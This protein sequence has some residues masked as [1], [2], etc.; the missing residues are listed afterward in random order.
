[1]IPGCSVQFAVEK[2]SG[3]VPISGKPH[4][5]PPEELVELQNHLKESVKQNFAQSSL[6][7]RECS[8]IFVLKKDT[9]VSQIGRAHV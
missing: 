1:M 3:D 6:F 2:T 7:P 5:V 9:T 8:T 4:S